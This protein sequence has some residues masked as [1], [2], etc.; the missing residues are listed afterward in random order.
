MSRFKEQGQGKSC[1]TNT[2]CSSNSAT[3][4]KLFWGKLVDKQLDRVPDII[5]RKFRIW[6]ALVEE[7]GIR[8]VRRCKGFHDEPLK[9]RLQ[10]QRSVRFNRAYR[11]IYV[12]HETGEVELIEVLEVNKHEYR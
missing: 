2:A 11:A 10:G 9:G 8:E 12:E 3:V 6:V 5:V 1:L 7:S 4:T